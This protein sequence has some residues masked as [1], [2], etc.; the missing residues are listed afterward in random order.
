[1]DDFPTETSIYRGFSIATCDYQ[2][3]CFIAVAGEARNGGTLGRTS[4]V[5]LGF[6]ADVLDPHDA[7][8]AMIDAATVYD[9]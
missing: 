2:R 3:V 5:L 7:H 4:M 1:M 8:A 9:C 6:G